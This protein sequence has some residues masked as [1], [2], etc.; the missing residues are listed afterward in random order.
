MSKTE[1]KADNDIDKIVT[2]LEYNLGDIVYF[3]NMIDSE[4]GYL[5][6]CKII[7]LFPSYLGGAKDDNI[8]FLDYIDIISGRD[9]GLDDFIED[10]RFARGS[11]LTHS[12]SIAIAKAFKRIDEEWEK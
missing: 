12:Q 2:E 10:N 7:A 8:Y 11:Q 3:F 6:R 5:C 9:K 4:S 1:E